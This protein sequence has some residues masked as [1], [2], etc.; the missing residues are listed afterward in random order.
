MLKGLSIRLKM[1]IPILGIAL[2][3]YVSSVVYVGRVMSQKSVEDA[4]KIT[5]LGAR[6]KARLV[7]A[8]FEGYLSLSRAMSKLIEDF[9]EISGAE[10]LAA[11]RQLL[12][13]V[14][15]SD[16]DLRL[17]WISWEMSALD[18][19]WTE[20]FGRERHAYV[21]DST[22]VV[23]EF[24]DTTDV[25]NHD[26]E[27]FYYTIRE[28]KSEGA[29][30]PYL[31][32]P[33][34][35]P[36]DLGT[37]IVSPIQKGDQYLGQVGFD[38][39]IER[40]VETTNFDTFERGYAIVISDKGRVVAHPDNSLINSYVDELSL[41]EEE[42]IRQVKSSLSRG[43]AL[44]LEK[45][46][47]YLGTEAY[48]NFVR[49]PIGNS[50]SFWTVG[51]VV[52]VSEI[53]KDARAII[54]NASIL[55]VL[56]LLALTLV[57][58]LI[59]RHIIKSIRRSENL[60]NNLAKGE[61][62]NS[63]R[64]V[65]YGADELGRMAQSVNSLQE[66]LGRKAAFAEEIGNGNMESAFEIS[67]KSDQFGKALIQMRENLLS[68]L[69][70]LNAV[71]SVAA[72]DGDLSVRIEATDKLGIWNALTHSVNDLLT[73]FHQP[74]RSIEA[75]ARL[76]AEG[77]LTERLDED[78]RGDIG[79]MT[80]NLNQGLQNL[81]LLLS[82]A[83]KAVQDI[84]G[85]A[86]IMLHDGMEMDT[87]TTEIAQS[88]H[89]MSNGAK[90][91]VD[92]IDQSSQLIEKI[93]QSSNEMEG[94]VQN[95]NEAAKSSAEKSRH[96]LSL[97]NNVNENM[98]DISDFSTKTNDSFRAFVERS[99]EISRVLSVITD[100]ASQTNLLA[101]NAAIEA[102][103][104]GDAGRGFA[105]VAEEI[106]K[107]AEDSRQ[108]VKSIASL[109]EDVQSDS[110]EATQ[111]LDMMNER[112]QAGA[113]SSQEASE[114][115]K[116]ITEATEGTLELTEGIN[117]TSASQKEAIQSVVGITE[118]VVIIA[119]ETAAGTE[120]VAT[121]ATQLA[122]GMAGFKK[123]AQELEQITQRLISAFEKFRLRE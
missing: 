60:L 23:S 63:T 5:D 54:R 42:D 84:R 119:E 106:R 1:L 53:S 77:D 90:S 99:N 48:A 121:S 92:Q 73:S 100:I 65:V 104:A 40:Y 56:G 116:G 37:S 18:P 87:S 108:S 120:E 96:G 64:L 6:E 61:I 49:I 118:S 32:N 82:D 12:R 85:S 24:R 36:D 102:A 39:S 75:M 78:M 93:M 3:S 21:M 66:A 41:F 25:T 76:M 68:V 19:S 13:K 57:I 95:I 59:T 22:G 58:S 20:D 114:A 79:E 103:Q 30:E 70:E 105:V 8:D 97:I 17:V 50:S 88:I 109:V 2:I 71:V 55:G 11:E 89:E 47:S 80:R 74:F 45:F 31:Y 123:R 98:G 27:N 44:A 16:P 117:V 52:P 28:S 67:G 33:V 113:K 83:I 34:A 107:L 7:Q 26:P 35:Y 115:F 10:R 62:D 4:Q 81:T 9:T 122:N 110:K 86:E 14:Q 15:E 46:D 51:T 69:N 101:L 29:A 72:E 91:Q 111:V 112:I 43:N 38:F 94:Q